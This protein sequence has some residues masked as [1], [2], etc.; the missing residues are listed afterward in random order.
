PAPFSP[1]QT[2]PQI[3]RYNIYGNVI[4]QPLI[5]KQGF[6]AKFGGSYKSLKIRFCL[7]TKDLLIYYGNE[8]ENHPK[9]QVELSRGATIS[10]SVHESNNEDGFTFP[11]T[12]TPNS[13]N[14]AISASSAS[15]GGSF[16]QSGKG[17]DDKPER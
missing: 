3:P 5:L 11:F 13:S 9:G 1:N 7:L 17:G 14:I 16:S 2:F 4:P 12:I 15:G 6:L 10:F 8:K